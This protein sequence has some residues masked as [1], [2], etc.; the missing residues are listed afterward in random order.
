MTLIRVE[1]EFFDYE[2]PSSD[3]RDL[4]R[5]I[6]LHCS[7]AP[8]L[9]VSWTSERQHGPG[10][11]PYSIA[12]A[13]SPYCSNEA[14]HVIDASESPLWARHIGRTIKLAYSRPLSRTLQHRVLE[15]RSSEQRT[16][17][18]SLSM[19]RVGISDTKPYS[20]F[21]YLLDLIN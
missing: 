15:V 10:D 18:Y 14:A 1:Y 13:Q 12:Y 19:D 5:Q 7:D 2:E 11:E 3:V 17:V 20:T 21:R 4:D 16:Y 6:R 9:Y 8:T